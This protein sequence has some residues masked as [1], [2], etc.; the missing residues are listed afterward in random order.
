MGLPFVSAVVSGAP[1][2]NDGATVLWGNTV[3]TAVTKVIGRAEIGASQYV[4]GKPRDA[5]TEAQVSNSTHTGY[6]YKAISSGTFGKQAAGKYIIP[7]VTTSIAGVATDVL[8]F[9]A[10]AQGIR[11]IA[12][13]QSAR[14]IRYQTA[15]LN[16]Y[17]G[18]PVTTPSNIFQLFAKDEVAHTN[19]GFQGE[20][21]YGK[22]GAVPTMADY[23]AKQ[24]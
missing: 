11:P 14:V 21:Q 7:Q 8:K 2:N 1:Q 12:F 4:P 23:P 18:E 10:S 22:T 3:G 6:T 24:G 20:F 19:R 9:A 5:S 16:V 17:T 15:G 13:T